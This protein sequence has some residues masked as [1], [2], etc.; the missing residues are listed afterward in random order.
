MAQSSADTTDA[1]SGAA[2]AAAAAPADHGDLTAI[3]ID[4]VTKRYGM[5]RALAKVSLELRAGSVCALL[6][7]N[8]A[9]K[10][11]LL[12]ILSTLVRPTSGTISYRDSSGA[13]PE[14]EQLRRHIGVLAHDSF[15][16]GEL[17]GLENLLFYAR[18]Y[19]VEN[20]AERATAL[21]D[22]VGLEESARSRPARTYSRGMLQRTALARAL[23]HDP[24]VLLLDEPFTGLD[25]RG[26]Q[27]LTEALAASKQHRRISLVITHD[28]EAIAGVT[29]HVAVLQRGRL[30]HEE[31]RDQ[32]VGQ[33]DPVGFSYQ[34]LTA[35]YHQH[36]T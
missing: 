29:D 11:T 3:T 35:L 10:S 33:A 17:S 12:G 8:G 6:G 22:D 27:A 25:R 34:E 14:P 4:K 36:T 32:A 24:P 7:P 2:S 1:A 23:L 9:G 20:P 19:G 18:L 26:A 21:L 28:L 31:R 16:Y 15:I 5:H 30:V 13:E